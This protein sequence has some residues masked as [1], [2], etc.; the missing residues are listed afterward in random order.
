[1]NSAG[2]LEIFA[3]QFLQSY[4]VLSSYIEQVILRK[5]I[6]PSPTKVGALMFLE[7]NNRHILTLYPPPD[8]L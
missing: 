7:T 1:M 8:K 6:G 2:M 3:L 4:S 5:H